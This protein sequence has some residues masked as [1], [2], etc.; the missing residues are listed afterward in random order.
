M[1]DLESEIR[2]QYRYDSPSFE[3]G[4]KTRSNAKKKVVKYEKSLEVKYE[5][6]YQQ[7]LNDLYDKI[8]NGDCFNFKYFEKVLIMNLYTEF[9]KT[10]ISKITGLSIRT[11]RNKINE[12]GREDL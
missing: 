4:E 12:Y 1:K 5:Y 8:D 9:N 10:Q 2:K 6:C 7:I 11:I 3:F